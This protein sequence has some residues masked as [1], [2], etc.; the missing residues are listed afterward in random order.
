MSR[1]HRSSTEAFLVNNV[2]NV[3]S[4]GWFDDAYTGLVSSHCPLQLP[5]QSV[6]CDSDSNFSH[7]KNSDGNE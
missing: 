6:H 7:L 4:G 5:A 2:R 3:T 1:L